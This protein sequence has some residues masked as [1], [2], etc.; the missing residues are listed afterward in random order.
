MYGPHEIST[1]LTVRVTI[2]AIQK[3]STMPFNGL[4]MHMGNLSYVSDAQTRSISPEYF[5]GEMGGGGRATDGTGA[6]PARDLGSGWKIS[7]S[8][9]VESGE[10]ATPANIEGAGAVQ[11]IW[12]TVTGHWRHSILRMYWDDQEKP[13]VETPVGDFFASGW[14]RYAQLSSLAVCVNPGSAFNS[15]WEMPFRRRA[16]ITITN[17]A[18]EKIVVYYQI[19]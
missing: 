16:R 19:N 10:T 13:S 15:Y 4:G 6:R 9:V 5:T 11:Q 18:E 3:E 7:P 2:V 17:I 14:N 1:A 8:I 12:M